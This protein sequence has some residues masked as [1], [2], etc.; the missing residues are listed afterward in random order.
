[1]PE[2][3]PQRHRPAHGVRGPVVAVHRRRCRSAGS[4]W[5][6]GSA[7]TGRRPPPAR[8]R[9]PEDADAPRRP[10]C[11]SRQPGT[12]RHSRGAPRRGETE[13]R[14]WHARIED[15]ALIG[16]LQTAALVGRDG[17]IDWLCLPR[18]DSGACFA[19]LLGDEDNG[20]WRIAP[21]RRGPLHPPRA[22]AAT[23]WSWR[24]CGRPPTGTRP[25]S[26]TSCRSA[27]GARRRRIVEGVRGRVADAQRAAAALR[28]RPRRA[29]GAPHATGTAVAIAG[30]DA[31]WLR[32]T[33]RA[34]STAR[35]SAR[36][37]DFAVDR[38]RARRLRADLAPLARAPAAP[39]RPV[40]GARSDTETTGGEL[41]GAA[42]ATTGRSG[43]PC[44]RSLI[45]LKALTYAPTGGIV[46]AATTSLPEQ[47]GGVRNWDYRYCWLR[48]ATLH[49]ARAARRR[50][51]RGGRAPGAT[52]CCAR[53]PAT[54]PTCRSCTASPASGGCP[55][56]SCPGC[57]A[58]RGPRRCGSATPP[59][60]SSSSTSTARSSTRCYLARSCGLAADGR[61]PGALQRALMD[62]LEMR[63]G[64]SPTRACGRCAA[65]RR[66]FVH[67]K[68][69]AW[70][71]ADRAVTHRGGRP[72]CAGP[73]DRWRAMRDEMHRE[74]CSEGFD[75]ER[76]TFTQ[77]YGSKELDAGLLLIPQV[78]FLPADDPR[79]RRHRRGD[80]ARAGPRRLRAPLH[81]EDSGGRRAAR[82]RG[83]L[84]GLLVLAR[85]RPAL[86]RPARR[87]PRRCSSGCSACA[88]TSACW[89]RST[90]RRPD[91]SSATSRRRS[92]TSGWSTPR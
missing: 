63:T 44:V 48:D 38:G 52:G 36:V 30:P 22:T 71:A 81:T 84:P 54:R 57:P 70:V 49:P 87:G 1:M 46:A 78:G 40:R 24:P 37:A 3:G 73:V 64:A 16:D 68:V 58:T 72:A 26:S 82:R 32:T 7:A 6:A 33:R 51:P 43:T 25:R 67:S 15:Y 20:H 41:V 61:T 12:R 83:R 17:S 55:S 60:S 75:A 27:T 42:A 8:Q 53:S 62:F 90:T 21:R 28:L 86:H 77:S 79:V 92:A 76:N 35:T 39:R 9:A 56:S 47:I 2:P 10:P 59:S 50:L 18:F 74:V 65:P 23:P 89:P 91:A 11:R 66:H 45:T 85:R 80:R 34:A 4:S 5:S 31:V 69:M 88:T 13:A 19:A 14:S 29:L